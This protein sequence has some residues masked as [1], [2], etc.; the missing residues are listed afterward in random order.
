MN[1][2]CV[3]RASASVGTFNQMSAAIAAVH[4]SGVGKRHGAPPHDFGRKRGTP[5]MDGPAG[6][7]APV[8]IETRQS[9]VGISK[10]GLDRARVSVIISNL[11][12]AGSHH[13][14]RAVLMQIVALQPRIPRSPRLCPHR[15]HKCRHNQNPRPFKWTKSADQ[16]LASL[17]RFCHKAQLTLCGEL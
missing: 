2:A 10:K 7:P 3:T 13:D 5:D 1:A 15:C 17:K 14:S 8:A 9:K 6:C 12:A 4:E 11:T 16:I